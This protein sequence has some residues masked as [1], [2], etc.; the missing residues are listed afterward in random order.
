M[1]RFA[2]NLL[3]Q[4]IVTG[5]IASSALGTRA[6][7]SQGIVSFSNTGTFAS[8]RDRNVYDWT[9]CAKMVGINYVAALYFGTDSRNI[10]SLAVRSLDDLTL[11]S[12]IV[13]FRDVDPTSPLAG[14]WVG[15]LRTL[16]GVTVG[17]MLMMQVRVWDI[18]MFATYEDSVAMRGVHGESTPFH[19]TVPDP[20]DMLGRKINNFAGMGDFCV[21]EPSVSMLTA[22]GVGLL[23]AW[24]RKNRRR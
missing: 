13:R 14:T 18:S 2:S 19:Y 23:F 20:D 1:K 21:P 11:A 5:L 17:Q 6:A 10:D 8:T 24:R 9:T 3:R 7:F 15:G 4:A 12:A 16:P 22:I